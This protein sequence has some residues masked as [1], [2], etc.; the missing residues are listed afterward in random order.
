MKWESFFSLVF[1]AESDLW[2]THFAPVQGLQS[3][4]E[5]DIV[6]PTAPYISEI[7]K[8]HHHASFGDDYEAPCKWY[9]R[10]LENLGIEEEKIAL[11]EGKIRPGLGIETLMIGG[12]KDVVCPADRARASMESSVEKGKLTVVDVDA[13][14]VSLLLPCY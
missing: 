7:D 4:L 6:V 10:G 2:K 11:R 9:V 12:L 1:P 3:Q 8:K 13:G 5:Q 14:H